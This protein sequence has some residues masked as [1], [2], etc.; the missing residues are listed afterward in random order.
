MKIN[1]PNHSNFNPY[2]KHVNQQADVQ[3]QKQSKQDKV[4]ISHQGK[5]LHESEQK[6]SARQK[7][8]DEIKAAVKDGKY[9]VDPNATAKKM[10]NFWSNKG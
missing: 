7:Y 5:A 4:E 2:K 10:V 9:Q 1:G 8:V 6:S 3:R